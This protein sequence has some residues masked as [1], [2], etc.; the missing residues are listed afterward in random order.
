MQIVRCVSCDGY[1]WVE[2]DGGQA[3]DC[4]WCAGV[5]YVYRDDAG[6]DHRIPESD[7]PSVAETLEHLEQERMRD[8]GYSGS[9]KHPREQGIRQ[10]R[11]DS[12]E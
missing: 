7:Y 9:P 8:L 6:I 4:D 1:G 10:R 2:D 5:G 12:D 11:E 3:A